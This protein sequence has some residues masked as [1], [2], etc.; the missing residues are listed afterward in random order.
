[1]Y[2]RCESTKKDSDVEKS[3]SGVVPSTYDTGVHV[4]PSREDQR[5][6]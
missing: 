3:V 1:M 6:M 5:S 4:T 2:F